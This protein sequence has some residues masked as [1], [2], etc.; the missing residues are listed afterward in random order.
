MS[1]DPPLSGREIQSRKGEPC[2]PSK[3]N[4]TMAAV[5]PVRA[6]PLFTNTPKATHAGAALISFPWT[7]QAAPWGADRPTVC[8]IFIKS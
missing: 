2:I 6:I 5:L 3:S 4:I 1:I 7:C 8:G